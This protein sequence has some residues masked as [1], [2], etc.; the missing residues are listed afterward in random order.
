V[1]VFSVIDAKVE[2]EIVARVMA[3]DERAEEELFLKYR[4]GVAI[5]LNHA[6]D[7]SPAAAD[8]CQDTFRITFQK[9]KNGELREPGKLPAFIWKVVHNLVTDHFRKLR[10]HQISNL[11][12]AEDV[13][14][15]SPDQLDMVLEKEKAALVRRVLGYME[16][17]RE[18]QALYRFYIAEE[19]KERVCA[20]LGLTAKQFNL[21]IFR[22]RKH[23]R[24]LYE[25]MV[26]G[27]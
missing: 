19:N 12:E 2:A 13:A 18:R 20:D 16:S 4:R 21:I 27:K 24:K 26:S 10:T 6:T 9:I 1:E 5:I 17:E 3:G 8:L 11:E 23:F 14:D 7:N 15:S 22:A 25:K